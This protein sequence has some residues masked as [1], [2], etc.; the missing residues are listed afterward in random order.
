MVILDSD[1]TKNHVLDE[2]RA[3]APLVTHA[4]VLIVEDTDSNGHPILPDFGPGPMEAVQEFLAA[5]S[6][7]M[8]VRENGS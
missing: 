8:L 2:L 6:D 7:F 5:T 4:S 3:Y 1:H